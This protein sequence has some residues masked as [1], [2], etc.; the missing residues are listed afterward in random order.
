MY[1][2]RTRAMHLKRRE[3]PGNEVVRQQNV[4]ALSRVACVADRLNPRLEFFVLVS[5][6]KSCCMQ[7]RQK[8]GTIARSR[9]FT[10]PYV[11]QRSNE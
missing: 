5:S 1:R 8:K 7:R 6:D 4:G 11:S 10:V 2:I 3:G 9:D